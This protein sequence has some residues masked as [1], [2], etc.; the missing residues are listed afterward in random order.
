MDQPRYTNPQTALIGQKGATLFCIYRLDKGQLRLCCWPKEK[1][2]QSTLDPE[3][4]DPPG[5][6][7]LMER[8]KD[9]GPVR[10]ARR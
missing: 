3:K 2:R 5:V 10:D 4:Q 1:E 8:P 9:T 7:L 6:L